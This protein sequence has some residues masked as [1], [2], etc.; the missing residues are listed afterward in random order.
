[1]IG[2]LHYLFFS[3]K[4]DDVPTINLD[5]NKR[6]RSS[7]SK[8]KRDKSSNYDEVEIRKDKRVSRKRAL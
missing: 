2:S 7:K 1:M 4:N 6:E 3:Q 5:D 8:D